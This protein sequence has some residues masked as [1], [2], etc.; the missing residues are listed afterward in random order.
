MS[1][2]PTPDDLAR[3]FQAH[4]IRA[5]TSAEWTR[6]GNLDVVREQRR[7]H[8]D[9]PR[10]KALEALADDLAR[11]VAAHVQLPPQDIATVLLAVGAITGFQ[12][13]AHQLPGPMVTEVIQIAA[14]LLDRQ[15]DGGEQK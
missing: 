13:L 3:Q 15:A 11:H 9:H 4:G 7:R 14:D 8:A 1:E 12:S 10:M 5:V 2:N 6:Q